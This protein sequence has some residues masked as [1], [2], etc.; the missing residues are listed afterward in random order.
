M[1]QEGEPAS[2]CPVL[3]AIP[4]KK[5]IIQ[6][7]LAIIITNMIRMGFCTGIFFPGETNAEIF[8]ASVAKFKGVSV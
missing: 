4:A 1:I 2:S 6:A 8:S 7:S 3:S 5:Q